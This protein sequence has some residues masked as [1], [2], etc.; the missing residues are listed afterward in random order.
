MI[1]VGYGDCRQESASNPQKLSAI[2][3]LC[4]LARGVWRT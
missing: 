4:F 1:P 3:A 2:A